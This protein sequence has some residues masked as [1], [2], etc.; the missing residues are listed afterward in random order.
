MADYLDE[1][2]DRLA[3]IGVDLTVDLVDRAAARLA[4]ASFA[5]LFD[6]TSAPLVLG[7]VWK[8]LLDKKRF[9]AECDLVTV[10]AVHHAA[11][12][13][14]RRAAAH[15]PD[16]LN[17]PG[18]WLEINIRLA[19]SCYDQHRTLLGSG[20]S[21][22]LVRNCLA[23]SFAAW[24][25][26][27]PQA[28]RV[29]DRRARIWRGQRA[30]GGLVLARKS[31][32]PVPLLLRAVADF[33][34]AFEFGDRSDRH[35]SYRIEALKRLLDL[36]YDVSE[37]AEAVVAAALSHGAKGREWFASLG[38]LRT[39][40]GVALGAT[41]VADAVTDSESERIL[42]GAV[43]LTFATDALARYAAAVDLYT[44]ALLFPAGGDL[45]DGLVGAKRGVARLRIAWVHR[46]LGR[47]QVG[48][49]D[50]AIA[51]LRYCGTPGAKMRGSALP[52][53][54]LQRAR[55]LRR[56]RQLD[57]ALAL[58]TEGHLYCLAEPEQVSAELCAGL[59]AMRHGLA[60]G[61]MLRTGT[62]VDAVALRVHL[63]GLSALPPDIRVMMW[64]MVGAAVRLV[65]AGDQ[66]AADRDRIAAVVDRL[67]YAVDHA[68]D[69]AIARWLQER[70]GRLC[71]HLGSALLTQVP[72]EGAQDQADATG[73]RLA[74]LRGAYTAFRS[75]RP[76]DGEPSS[77]LWWALGLAA[78]HYAKSLRHMDPPGSQR[79]LAEC[80]DCLTRL[81]DREDVPQV[82]SAADVPRPTARV[83]GD[84]DLD[85][86]AEA[87][88]QY[89]LPVRETASYLG[90]AFL[91]L[92]TFTRA[93]SD[94]A[95]S[96]TWLERSVAAG[97]DSEAMFGLLG[98]AH[99]RHGRETNSPASFQIALAHKAR[100][101][102]AGLPGVAS[103]ENWSVSAASHRA[104]WEL[105]HD[106]ADFV[107]AVGFAW[108]A[109]ATDRA[110]PWPMVQLLDLRDVAGLGEISAIASAE[111]ALDDQLTRM[112][113]EPEPTTLRAEVATR[114][115]RNRQFQQH[116]LGG[117][118]QTFV[119]NDPHR[120]LSVSLVIKPTSRALATA[121]AART[122]SLDHYLRSSGAPHWMQVPVV[123]DAV[124]I[125]TT[126]LD[127]VTVNSAY[128][129][130][131]ALGRSLAELTAARRR[132]PALFEASERALRFLA[133][134]H[135]SQG[136][137]SADHDG[138]ALGQVARVVERFGARAGI[139]DPTGLASAW[140]LHAPPVPIAMPGR[141]G[142]AENW[143]VTP[144]GGVTAL[145]FEDHPRH[146]LLY[147]AVQLIEDH[148]LLPPED[149]TREQR[150]GLCRAYL[151][152]L[153][154]VGEPHPFGDDDLWQVYRA[155]AFVRA[156]FLA[157]YLPRKMAAS[158]DPGFLHAA[159]AR[160]R[161][162]RH[163]IVYLADTETR[164]ELRDV[165]ARA[166]RAVP[167]RPGDG[168]DA[169]GRDAV[170][171]RR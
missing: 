65:Y 6:R 152:E 100:A 107:A 89:V 111:P 79:L 25:V 36:G 123:I 130:R 157:G 168:A 70:I 102:A 59:A 14:P 39:S 52:A 85:A 139:G 116:V 83:T 108:Q 11:T 77:E 2:R 81:W 19:G 38:D 159:D 71:A 45:S 149:G 163:L 32:E 62:E 86:E 121:E 118:S 115:A 48:I 84:S 40:Q 112:F 3:T 49:L 169:A 92:H 20:G 15:L 17:W 9:D 73:T 8:S 18:T 136:G 141:D 74:W 21:D 124:D 137:G 1:I 154:L 114:A 144:S 37:E 26:I 113:L 98:D 165:Y 66:S 91:R 63:D 142:H 33:A 146:P 57:E 51:A 145:D 156:V 27:E 5:G 7:A 23:E 160:Y 30:V 120:L 151:D 75:A 44:E 170:R 82:N 29:V 13:S 171:S 54:L 97:N 133:R 150:L 161:H 55:E 24:D 22:E 68:S 34:K 166:M 94:L 134:I 167:T 47:P 67:R 31:D 53:A 90:E 110:W 155:F 105:R 93:S 106:P 127:G 132:G 58:A 129:T 10:V 60:L 143:L 87:E 138:R 162:A 158:D 61:V 56:D 72:D 131:R 140:T 109:T 95:G 43:A 64:P 42:V 96:I 12:H 4:P 128:V 41:L 80:I 46:L 153:A 122:T 76:P 28:G 104:L 147:E 69:D 99:Y 35:F 88:S 16:G 101:R 164:P 78:L 103:R 50:E 135:C 126:I 117:R 148:A 119:L 125:P